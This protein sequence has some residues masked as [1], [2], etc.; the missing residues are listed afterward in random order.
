M[1]RSSA[2]SIG[3]FSRTRNLQH[4]VG[5]RDKGAEGSPKDR[6]VTEADAGNREEGDALQTIMNC[7]RDGT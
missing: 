1:A 4:F 5:S 6:W 7:V 3:D 2:K